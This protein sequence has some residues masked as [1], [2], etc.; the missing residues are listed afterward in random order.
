MGKAWFRLLVG[1]S[2]W[3]VFSVRSRRKILKLAGLDIADTAVV[4]GG[5]K[6]KTNN[7]H[8]GQHSLINDN[9]HFY[10]SKDGRIYIGDNVK[11][12]FDVTVATPTHQIGDSSQRS[13]Q[14]E[15]RSVFIGDGCWIGMRA[16]ILPGVNIGSGCVVGGGTVVIKDC[17]ENS[18]YVGVPARKVRD[19]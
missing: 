6:F 15:N 9:C 1:I 12:A 11:I 14:S 17:E 13:G 10:T 3:S 19:L 4:C 2:T 18:L 16:V 7:V 5:V 8:I